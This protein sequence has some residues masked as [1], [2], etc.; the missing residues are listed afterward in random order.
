MCSRNSHRRIL[1]ILCVSAILNACSSQPRSTYPVLAQI[2]ESDDELNCIGFDDELLKANA[3]R[4]AVFD[5][6]GDV[7]GEAV[8]DAVF[9]TVDM[10]N[11]PISVVLFGLL[12][13]GLSAS[14]P[15]K[16]YLEAA[17]AAGLRM[18]QMLVYKDRDNCPNGPTRA[19]SLTDSEVLHRLQDLES[20]LRQQEITEKQYISAR[21]AMLDS[22]R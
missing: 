21:R 17:V 14:N 7:M 2:V 1:W 10:A 3:I 20:Q 9:S 16:T 6:H 8:L 18:E 13:R 4:D 15:S 12:I 5:E 22:L 19:S 11:M